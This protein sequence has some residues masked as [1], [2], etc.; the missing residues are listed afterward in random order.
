MRPSEGAA[1]SGLLTNVKDHKNLRWSLQCRDSDPDNDEESRFSFKSSHGSRT[2][3]RGVVSVLS[4]NYQLYKPSPELRNLVGRILRV[5]KSLALA[6]LLSSLGFS[7]G[8]GVGQFTRRTVG[9]DLNT[10][11]LP[12]NFAWV[13]LLFNLDQDPTE[14]NG[15]V[16][17]HGPSGNE[18]VECLGAFGHCVTIRIA[19]GVQ[20][21]YDGL[22]QPEHIKGHLHI[23]DW[24]PV[25]S[26]TVGLFDEV[27]SIPIDIEVQYAD[28]RRSVVISDDHKLYERLK[29]SI[30]GIVRVYISRSKTGLKL[31][32]QAGEFRFKS[33]DKV[34]HRYV[35]RQ[36]A[37]EFL[38]P[39]T[40]DVV[41][42]LRDNTVV[43]I[44]TTGA[45]IADGGNGKSLVRNEDLFDLVSPAGRLIRAIM[46]LFAVGE[47]YE[48]LF[49]LQ[50]SDRR[51]MS[52]ITESDEDNRYKD[53]C[54]E[55]GIR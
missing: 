35:L 30:S 47:N 21:V 48:P 41:T 50:D 10:S 1:A 37:L 31:W 18:I 26:P 8:G 40:I 16:E 20:D 44:D 3:L 11:D 53:G 54:V 22:R 38:Y 6:F 14:A 24:F 46:K 33:F 9:E 2:Y 4:R 27:V 42:K 28:R 55:I 5:L 43:P 45:R 19:L 7:Q 17:G 12:A 23:F 52:G 34:S 15:F 36:T 51:G 25:P 29:P 13:D 39:C 49:A 32:Q